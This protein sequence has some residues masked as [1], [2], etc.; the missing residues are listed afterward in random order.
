MDVR[1]VNLNLLVAL[2]SLLRERSVTAAARRTGVSQPAMSHSLRQ[3][4]GLFDDP[5]LVRGALSP[6]AEALGPGLALGL[7]ELQQVLDV[8]ETFD[9]ASSTRSFRIAASDTFQVMGLRYL[10]ADVQ[11]RAPGVNVVLRPSVEGHAEALASGRVTLTLGSREQVPGP[12]AVRRELYRER[13]ACI[14]RA[15]HPAVNVRLGLA[16]YCRLAHALVADDEE[17]GYLDRILAVHG[18]TRRVAVRL[19]DYAG[20]GHVVAGTDLV[21]TVPARLAERLAQTFPLR[22]MKPPVRLEPFPVMMAWHPR[23]DAE[24]GHRWLRDRVLALVGPIAPPRQGGGAAQGRTTTS[25]PPVTM[26]GGPRPFSGKTSS[27]SSTTS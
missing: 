15:D 27:P 7:G 3:L 11:R 26:T 4:R 25:S 1:A 8:R 5:L 6:L 24:P 16:T 12:P 20:I 18:R 17:P 13:F 14:V 23:F 9:P 2:D 22:V 10:L 19:P 21:A